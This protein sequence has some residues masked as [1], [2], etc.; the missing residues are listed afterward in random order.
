MKPQLGV[1]VFGLLG[2]L[3]SATADEV[4]V[5]LA[6]AVGEAAVLLDL[7]EVR[8]IDASGVETLRDVIGSIHHQGGRSAISRPRRLAFS[9]L[10]L[11]GTK[12]LVFLALSPAGAIAWLD[13][14]SGGQPTDAHHGE[15]LLAVEMAVELP[16]TLEVA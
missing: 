8:V 3:D 5:L 10:G 11:S 2:E 6:S 9:L 4:R 12:G 16:L 1:S 15:V 7:S 14:H 13:Q